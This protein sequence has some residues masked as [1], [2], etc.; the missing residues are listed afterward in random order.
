[1]ALS[2][3][4]NAVPEVQ[5]AVNVVKMRFFKEKCTPVLSK[6]ASYHQLLKV[7]NVLTVNT[8]DQCTEHLTFT[9]T[10][11]ATIISNDAEFPQNKRTYLPK[12]GGNFCFKT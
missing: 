6:N 5:N 9:H 12:I 11:Y 7:Y 1:M 2:E 3:N 4:L 10:K 8:T